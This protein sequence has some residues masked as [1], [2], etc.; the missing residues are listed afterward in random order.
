MADSKISVLTAAT[1]PLAGTEIV[2]IVQDGVTKQVSAADLTAGRPISASSATIGDLSLS[3]TSIGSATTAQIGSTDGNS[4][5]VKFQGDNINNPNGVPVD[6]WIQTR[7]FNRWF[8]LG[9]VNGAGWRTDGQYVVNQ[10]WGAGAEYYFTANTGGV[11]LA[12]GATSWAAL[13]DL[14]LKNVIEQISQPLD[15]IGQIESFVYSFKFD[16]V[17]KRRIGVSAQSVQAVVPEAIDNYKLSPDDTETYLSVR[18]TELVPLLIAGIQELT[19]QVEQLKS[20]IQTL[21]GA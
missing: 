4:A 12:T 16:E 19:Q 2:P 11:L 21:K 13:S 15:K 14:R 7:G 6:G 3:G 20:E 17:E 5:Y 1:T 18:Y 9:G 8:M 10:S